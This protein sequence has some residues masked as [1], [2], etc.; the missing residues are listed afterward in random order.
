LPDV[1]VDGETGLLVTPGS[2]EELASSMRR[3]SEDGEL[4]TRMGEA[5]SRRVKEFSADAIIP[6]FEEVYELAL[7]ARRRKSTRGAPG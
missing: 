5:A 2:R 3:L 7:E 1:V 6:R 4:R